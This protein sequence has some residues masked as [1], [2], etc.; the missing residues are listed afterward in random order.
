M[1]DDQ[2]PRSKPSDVSTIVD[3]QIAMAR[4][5]EELDLDRDV[6]TRGV[7][8]VF[9]DRIPRPLLPRGERRRRRSRR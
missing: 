9:E 4:E 2:L 8:A 3:F 6:C 1:T 7:Q 5:T